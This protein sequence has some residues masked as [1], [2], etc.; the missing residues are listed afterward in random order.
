[1]TFAN[2]SDPPSTSGRFAALDAR[3]KSFWMGTLAGLLARYDIATGQRV[4]RWTAGLGLGGIGRLRPARAATQGPGSGG[5]TTTQSTSARPAIG[6]QTFAMASS[7][8]SLD[9]PASPSPTA[10]CSRPGARCC[11]T[12]ASR[13]AAPRRARSAL[14]TSRSPSQAPGAAQ[15]PHRRRASAR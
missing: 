6:A 9:M 2:P 7:V 8:P 11:S 10:G 3:R 5:S 13:S 4:D 15:A 1:V 12:R 14:R